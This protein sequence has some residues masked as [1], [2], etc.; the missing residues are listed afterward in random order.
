MKH[1]LHCIIWQ[2][3]VYRYSIILDV[4]LN[5][6]ATHHGRKGFFLRCWK[7]YPKQYSWIIYLA[8]V[9]L[10]VDPHRSSSSLGS[11]HLS[12]SLWRVRLKSLLFTDLSWNPASICKV[13]N[14][15]CCFHF[16]WCW[17]HWIST[18]LIQVDKRNK[19]ISTL[20]VSSALLPWAQ[21]AFL[22]LAQISFHR[23]CHIVELVEQH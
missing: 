3:Q 14:N 16:G 5:G 2:Y 15:S 12:L 7:G 4:I 22:V 19:A 20:E 18:K 21:T 6:Y 9:C 8:I 23:Y 11:S 10:E 1:I 13:I 17:C